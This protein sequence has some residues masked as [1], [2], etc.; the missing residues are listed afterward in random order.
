MIR[1][2]IFG[3]A[4]LITVFCVH[5]SRAG[6]DGASVAVE[7]P[8]AMEESLVTT[9]ATTLP[10]PSAPLLSTTA[11]IVQA[12]RAVWS[13]EVQPQVAS[14]SID[15]EDE[16]VRWKIAAFC[17]E[18]AVYE[19]MGDHQVS[20]AL[21]AQVKA[22]KAIQKMHEQG[23]KEA[24]VSL[25]SKRNRLEEQQS[26]FR[27]GESGSSDQTA[28]LQKN[29][30]KIAEAVRVTLKVSRIAHG[31]SLQTIAQRLC[32]EYDDLRSA[33]ADITESGDGSYPSGL[34]N[35]LT[36]LRTSDADFAAL[37]GECA[38]L[39]TVV[40]NQWAER[41]KVPV[42]TAAQSYN[43]SERAAVARG[44]AAH[45]RLQQK[46]FEQI[47]TSLGLL[48]DFDTASEGG[49]AHDRL[50]FEIE[51]IKGP[52]NSGADRARSLLMRGSQA[53]KDFCDLG[54]VKELR[55]AVMQ[56]FTAMKTL[57]PYASVFQAVLGVLTS[58]LCPGVFIDWQMQ[59]SK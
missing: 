4:S 18:L 48:K 42:A 26:R 32:S 55:S 50:W 5:E 51:Q 7:L 39:S 46:R 27:T 53:V 1:K 54:P 49:P 56:Q 37:A 15:T 31:Q 28:V 16:M 14:S 6:N 43:S 22:E 13:G 34:T 41:I 52:S 30:G 10:A 40:A 44:R 3:I 45:C 20:V 17:E 38:D 36:Q 25:L 57:S 12:Y 58:N 33:G 19:T 35:L 2:Y 47:A 24:V 11:Q 59:R 21:G 29:L 9:V 8:P 23:A